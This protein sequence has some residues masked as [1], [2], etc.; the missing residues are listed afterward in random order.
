MMTGQARLLVALGTVGLV[1]GIVRQQ[2]SAQL[3]SLTLLIWLGFS[4]SIFSWRLW[5]CLRSLQVERSIAGRTAPYGPL[6]AGKKTE[7]HVR[8]SCRYPVPAYTSIHDLVGRAAEIEG[9]AS[10]LLERSKKMVDFRYQVLGQGAGTIAFFGVRCKFVDRTGLFTRVHVIPEMCRVRVLPQFASSSDPRPRIKR[11]NAIPHQ[12]IHQMQRAGLGSELLDLRDYQIGDPPKSIAWKVSARR[13]RLMTRQY[14]SEVPVKINLLVE[15]GRE[16]WC[17]HPGER[18]VDRTA[19]LVASACRAVVSAG[20][21]LSLSLIGMRQSIY[22]N[23]LSGERGFYRVLDQLSRFSEQT[24]PIRA[25][26]SV[27][28]IDSA[29]LL[30]RYLRPDLF[31]NWVNPPRA[32]SLNPWP[33]VR[34][35]RA[36]RNQF[37]YAICEHYQLSANDALSLPW[38]QGLLSEYAARFLAEHQQQTDVEPQP[39]DSTLRRQEYALRCQRVSNALK[40]ILVRAKDNQVFVI[41][42]SLL[43]PASPHSD[44]SLTL[45]QPVLRTIIGKHHRVCLVTTMPAAGKDALAAAKNAEPWTYHMLRR[46]AAAILEQEH[47]SEMRNKIRSMGITSVFASASTIVPKILAEAELA[48]RGRHAGKHTERGVHEPYVST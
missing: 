31:S 14:Q 19:F 37:A 1:F 46:H 25:G 27:K 26:S 4:Y 22:A 3:A 17:G 8:L 44:S 29:A 18:L 40:Q 42:S 43:D 21:P 45:V 24:A 33:R 39:E 41:F 7:V 38:D 32:R 5:N 36:V 12:G 10:L 6:W 2:G 9:S 47:A 30:L 23:D 15:G 28:C 48:G 11:S 20:D 16:M 13:D 35:N 34:R